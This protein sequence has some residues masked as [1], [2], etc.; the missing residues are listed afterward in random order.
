ML[1]DLCSKAVSS[2]FQGLDLMG[3]FSPHSLSVD[4]AVMVS[5]TNFTLFGDHDDR[6]A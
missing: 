6:L 3:Q 2:T 4:A 1:L 5:K